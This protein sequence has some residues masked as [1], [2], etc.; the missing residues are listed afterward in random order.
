[1]NEKLLWHY[2]TLWHLDDIFRAGRLKTA[3][4]GV[5]RGERRAVWFSSNQRFEGTVQKGVI[6]KRTGLEQHFSTMDEIHV[7]LGLVRFGVKRD[8]APFV[9]WPTFKE[10]SG[11]T[12]TEALALEQAGADMGADP[13]DWYAVFGAV[14]SDKWTDIQVWSGSIWWD[15]GLY[16]E[17]REYIVRNPLTGE[18]CALADIS[19]AARR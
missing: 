4:K 18:E 6:D 12:E 9:D 19:P 1:V 8:D 3:S 17:T 15:L 11:I 13:L 10:T 14:A 7:A 16:R 2:T 5:R